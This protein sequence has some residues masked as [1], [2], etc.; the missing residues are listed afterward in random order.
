MTS[1][2]PV[3]LHFLVEALL[4]GC[5]VFGESVMVALMARSTLELAAALALLVGIFVPVA[6]RLGLVIALT[7][8]LSQRNVLLLVFVFVRVRV[9]V[10]LKPFSSASTVDKALHGS[11]YLFPCFWESSLFWSLSPL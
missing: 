4:P 5:G 9:T 7:T 8:E 11:T 10:F 3:A 2:D 6:G 1:F